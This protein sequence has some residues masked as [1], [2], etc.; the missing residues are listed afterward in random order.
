MRPVLPSSLLDVL[1]SPTPF[2]IG[3]HSVNQ[4]HVADLLD[5]IVVDLDGGMIHIPE[6][7]TLHKVMEPLRTQVVYELS[8]VL[9][10]ELYLADNAFQS[11]RGNGKSPEM[12]DKELRAVMLRLMTQLLQV[13]S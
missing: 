11:S 6:N 7:M 1:S 3:V 4:D 10:P 2:I 9:H 13:R 5:V 12:L 8:S